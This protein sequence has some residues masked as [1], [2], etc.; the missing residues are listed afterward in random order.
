MTGGPTGPPVVVLGAQEARCAVDTSP[1]QLLS[2][3]D[4]RA[5]DGIGIIEVLVSALIVVLVSL[6]V[7]AAIDAAGHT[8][9]ANKS[10]SVASSLAQ[11]DQ[12]RLRSMT[13]SQVG[14]LDQTR[15][16]PVDGENYSVRSQGQYVTG[17]ADATDCTSTEQ[18]PKY[19]KITSTVTWPDIRG[20]KP[21]TLDSLRTVPNGSVSGQGT[22]VV[23]SRAPRGPGSRASP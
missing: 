7:F 3:I 16:V 21:V 19:L 1:V 5:E 15:A 23:E 14:N 2:R 11:S 13:I 17:P 20:V 18:N 8:A 10:R 22:L 4:A 9:D 6:G 12:E